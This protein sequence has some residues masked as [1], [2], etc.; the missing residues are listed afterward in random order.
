MACS[1]AKAIE[2][3]AS[4]SKNLE[5]SGRAAVGVHNSAYEELLPPVA[6]GNLAPTMI[7]DVP[8]MVGIPAKELTIQS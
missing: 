8:R 5:P 2:W 4:W 7:D 3:D 1:T 6:N